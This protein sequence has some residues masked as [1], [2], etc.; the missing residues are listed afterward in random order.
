MHGDMN[1]MTHRANSSSC[2]DRIVHSMLSI[3]RRG[4]R[5]HWMNGDCVRSID[6][7]AWGN[8]AW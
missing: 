3:G 5:N 6:S 7:I 2:G 1:V 8:S 4:D